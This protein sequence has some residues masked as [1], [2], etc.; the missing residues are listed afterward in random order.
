MNQ[1][2][3]KKL[4]RI[5]S[6]LSRQLPGRGLR[7]RKLKQLYNLTPKGKAREIKLNEEEVAK[8]MLH[9]I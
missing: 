5:H 6:E 3:A 9:G 8:R 4:R 2:K 7:L 1:K